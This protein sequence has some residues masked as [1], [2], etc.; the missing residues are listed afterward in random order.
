MTILILFHW[1]MSKNKILKR[2]IELLKDA[3]EALLKYS[4]K[5][6]SLKVIDNELESG[7]GLIRND[8]DS[9]VQMNLLKQKVLTKDNRQ[10]TLLLAL[11]SI[12]GTEDA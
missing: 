8:F 2:W 6:W 5:N 9:E 4:I 7:P 1:I 3:N 11:F 10:W 12:W